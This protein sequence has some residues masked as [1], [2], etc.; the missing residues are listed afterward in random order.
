MA[1]YLI[2]GD[3]HGRV[4][5]AFALARAWQRER[6]EAVSALLQV[7]DLGY[8]PFPDRLDRATKKYARDDELE[9]GAQLI[10]RPN[11]LADALF[12]D[13]DTPGP[14][15][16]IAGNHEDHEAL[17]DC[18]G[19]PGSGD[20]D[21]PVDVYGRVRCVVDGHVAEMPGGLRVGGLWG[22]D[23]AP[24][25]RRHVP[26]AARLDTRRARQLAMR[27]FDMLLTHE[28]PRDAFFEDAGSE[29]ISL[30]I[31]Q[32]RPAF[33]FHGHYHGEPPPGGRDYAPTRVV[34]LEGVE[35]RGKRG[36]AEE[37]SVGVLRVGEAGAS[38]EYVD[39]A[40]L[41]TVTRDN[42]QTR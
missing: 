28:S 42:W 6:G 7:G 10:V 26:R 4:L 32:A 24:G 17:A 36:S 16:F 13:P 9:L 34:H 31:E 37:R 15:W 20:D 41:R 22:I 8:Y 33:A 30:V 1:T 40:W 3:L 18:Y 2:F 19:V 12:A 35:F 25:A 29:A 27:S 11:D 38:F 5:P 21:F 23:E 39:P 14:M